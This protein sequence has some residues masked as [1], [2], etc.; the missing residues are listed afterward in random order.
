MDCMGSENYRHYSKNRLLGLLAERDAQ[1]RRLMERLAE[2]DRRLGRLD[3]VAGGRLGRV[4]GV[5]AKAG[6]LGRQFL[7]PGR[8]LGDQLLQLGDAGLLLPDDPLVVLFG[9]GIHGSSGRQVSDTLIMGP[10]AATNP[11]LSDFDLHL[12]GG[13]LLY[14]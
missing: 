6:H 3:D 11:V 4:R 10:T 8:Q 1:I 14:S 7:N 13:G 5:L 12:P 9:A 2:Q